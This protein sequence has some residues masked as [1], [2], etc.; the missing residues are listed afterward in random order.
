MYAHLRDNGALGAVINVT[1]INTLVSLM[2]QDYGKLDD[3]LCAAAHHEDISSSFKVDGAPIFVSKPRLGMCITGTPDQLVM[4]IV[5]L[6]NGLYSRFAFLTAPSEW[7]WRSAAPIEGEMEYRLY[8]LDLG[9]EVL[10]MH[11]TLIDSPT[12]VTFKPAQW[13]E[14]TMRF[15]ELLKGVAVEGEDSPGAIVKRHGL[16]AMRLASIFTTLRKQEDHWYAKE[17]ICTDEDFHTAM[18]MV[19]VLIEHSLLLAS[20]LPGVKL[21]SRPLQ[22]FHRVHS[23]LDRLRN[24]FT[25]SEFIKEAMDEQV[26]EST[27]KRW[28]KRALAGDFVE[29]Q[30]G[31]Y[32]KKKRSHGDRGS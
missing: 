1:E 20:S 10:E 12:E 4:L 24:P 32:R 17:V 3:V 2:G 6:E 21:K 31:G 14:H 15:T 8:Y 25:Y 23:V 30:P 9:K 18:S 29:N 27:A 16:L 26:S 28:L 5:T 7:E 22:K 11:N 19:E 13:E